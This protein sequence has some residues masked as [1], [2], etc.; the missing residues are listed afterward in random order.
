MNYR[1]LLFT[2]ALAIVCIVGCDASTDKHRVQEIPTIETPFSVEAAVHRLKSAYPKAEVKVKQNRIR[3]MYGSMS[4][5]NTPKEAADKFIQNSASAFG[6]SESELALDGESTSLAGTSGLNVRRLSA[7]SNPASAS[8][9]SNGV[10]LMYDPR[11]GKHKFRLYRYVQ[12]RNGVPVYGAGLRTLV[13]EG[14][15][16]EVVWANADVKPMGHFAASA[17]AIAPVA[18]MEKSLQ[19]LESADASIPAP[20]GFARV[21]QPTPTVFAGLDD[22]ETP[23]MAMTYTA[24][25][26]DGIGAWTF[27]ADAATGDILHV[28]SNIHGDTS[29][30]EGSDFDISGTVYASVN[31][32]LNAMECSGQEIVPL[33]YLHVTASSTETTAAAVT[34][35]DGQYSLQMPDSSP[36]SVVS[37]INGE[38]FHVVDDRG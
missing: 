33:P 27:V 37:E 4:T 30:G 26:A 16:N 31:S 5:G 21:S 35:L 32:G 14:D 2:S 38:Y 10:G 29:P 7:T 36:A 19:A 24:E 13:R 8:A 22:I 1:P 28:E 20:T 23:R 18:D 11:T 9:E 34:N 15:T 17:D 6:I 3:R 25:A 12:H